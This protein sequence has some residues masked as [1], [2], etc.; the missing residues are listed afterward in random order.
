[1]FHFSGCCVLRSMDSIG[2][3]PEL[4][5]TGYP[6]RKSAGRGLFA[7][8]R[9]LSQLITSFF[10]CWHQGIH[11]ALL[12][13]LFLR[14][15]EISNLCKKPCPATA[16]A[17]LA[18]TQQIVEVAF[19]LPCMRMSKS[20]PWDGPA[21]RLTP[22][23]FLDRRQNSKRFRIFQHSVGLIGLEPMT[24]R[25]SSACS[26][27]LSYRPV[28]GSWPAISNLKSQISNC[29]AMRGVEARGFEPLTSSLQSW[30]ST[31]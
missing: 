7:A 4:P 28:A 3:D 10:A 29:P 9:G 24:L 8:H 2:D 13:A 21:A 19:N 27:Q 30:R 31:N 6:I 11:H 18:Q 16:E 5:G 23:R 14:Y 17:V 15:L 20:W 22:V 1:M 12:V 25:L 26:N